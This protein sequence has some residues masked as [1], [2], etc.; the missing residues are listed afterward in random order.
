M[1]ERKRPQTEA[2]SRNH[3]MNGIKRALLVM[4]LTVA[5]T[6]VAL[7]AYFV[8]ARPSI[9][10]I[11]TFVLIAPVFLILG[12]GFFKAARNSN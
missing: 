2:A 6:V 5:L 1:I 10:S 3:R 11:L 9:I 8:F 12:L 7:V 4:G